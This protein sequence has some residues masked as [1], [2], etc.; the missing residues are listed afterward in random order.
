[1]LILMSILT[2]AKLTGYASREYFL[3]FLLALVPMIFGHTLYNWALKY[4]LAPVVSVSLL[5]E[6]IGASILAL[7]FLNEV[8]SGLVLIGGAITLAGILLSSYHSE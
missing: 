4:V 7:L 6:P 1:V 2:G 3:F 8:P 5:G